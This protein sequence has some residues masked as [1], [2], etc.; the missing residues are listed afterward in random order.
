MQ[1]DETTEQIARETG[2]G[3]MVTLENNQDDTG[4]VTFTVRL[5]RDDPFPEN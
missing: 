2:N 5:D 1:S 3:P 4:R